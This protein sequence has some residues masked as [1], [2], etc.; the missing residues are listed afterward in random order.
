MP[1]AYL[2]HSFL[3][4]SS[5]TSP[6]TVHRELGL[7]QVADAPVIGSFF[8]NRFRAS[9]LERGNPLVIID[10]SSS[11]ENNETQGTQDVLREWQQISYC[12][13]A[14]RAQWGSHMH[15]VSKRPPT[16]LGV[17]FLAYRA[18]MGKPAIP[19]LCRTP[20]LLSMVL[21][22]VLVLKRVPVVPSDISPALQRQ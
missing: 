9:S 7:L 12:A 22:L 3:R 15:Q 4:C 2:P 13:Y 18:G 8:A 19:A 21:I 10:S 5:K 6:T 17:L 16:S 1:H 14:G 11:S 20:A